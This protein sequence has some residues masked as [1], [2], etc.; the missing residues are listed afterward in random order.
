VAE[1]HGHPLVLKKGNL[2]GRVFFFFDCLISK[3]WRKKNSLFFTKKRQNL[4]EKDTD[5]VSAHSPTV[6][7]GLAT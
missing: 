3:D 5:P 7:R 2:I 4:W 1:G 6:Q